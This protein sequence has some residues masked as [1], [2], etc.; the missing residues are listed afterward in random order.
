[1]TNYH[2]HS[3]YCD[4][5]SSLREMVEFALAHGF[6]HLGFSGHAPL[7]YENNFS[8]K[9][10]DYLTYCQEVRALQLEF[11]GRIEISL[12]LE[13]D[14]IP[15][16]HENFKPL[17]EKGGLDYTIGSVHLI[18]NPDSIE[19]LRDHPAE[20]ADYLWMIDGSR[21]QTYDEGLQRHYHGDIRRGVRDFFRQNN[22]MIE[23]QKPTIVGHFDKIVMH[24]RDRYF[25]YDEPWF[26]NYVYETVELIRETGCICEVNTRGIY[27]GRHNDF[28]P[29]KST[30]QHMSQLGILVIVSTDAHMASD[31]V[32]TEGA[33]EFLQEIHYREVLT[34]LTY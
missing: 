33:A 34:T 12:G 23:S 25:H 3:T 28:Y 14:Y 16:L 11:A 24:N 29:A 10:D 1:M 27:K 15:G 21:Y 8:I 31:L 20:A 17:I 9:D 30:L 22:A 2:T 5:K 6:S 13:I 18:P 26:R 32:L 19:Y 7:P 4:G